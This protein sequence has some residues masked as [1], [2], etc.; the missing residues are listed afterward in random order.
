[1][2]A[3]GDQ[4]VKVVEERKVSHDQDDG[5]GLRRGG[6]ERARDDTIDSVGAAVREKTDGPRAAREVGIHVAHRHRTAG[7]QDPAI[8]NQV[9]QESE[10]PGLERFGR[11][12]G[13]GK[14]AGQG[15]AG[16]SVRLQPFAHPG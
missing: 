6:P 9:R 13:T 4:R 5:S 12:R 2:E 7:P 8:R 3:G 10:R 16:G 15:L 11:N 1:M 14:P